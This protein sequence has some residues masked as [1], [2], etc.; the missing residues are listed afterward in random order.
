MLV[1]GKVEV[2]EFLGRR[3]C[4][5]GKFKYFV[6]TLW[7]MSGRCVL[8]YLFGTITQSGHAILAKTFHRPESPRDQAVIKSYLPPYC[9]TYNRTAGLITE[10][11]AVCVSSPCRSVRGRAAVLLGR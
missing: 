7:G 8:E 5:E 9:A 11:P 4:G 1:V 6:V 2:L 3:M 10:R